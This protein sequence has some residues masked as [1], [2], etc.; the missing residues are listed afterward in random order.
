M[1]VLAVASSK[2]GVG[3]TSVAVNLAAGFAAEGARTLLVDLDPGGHATTWLLGAPAKVGIAD[4]ILA[5]ELAPEHV[6]EVPDRPRLYLAPY[7]PALDGIE[8]ALAG[9]FGRE[10]I[11]AEV[12]KAKRK[13]Q[14]EMVV[15]DCQ[16]TK[17]FLAQSAVFAASEVISP[18]LPGIL[19]VSGV[20][21]I[22][23]LVEQVRK[24]GRG[25][26]AFLGSVI[27]AGD[28]RAMLTQ[29]TRESLRQVHADLFRSEVRVSTA[30]ARLP[31]RRATAWDPGADPRGAEDYSELLKETKQR[32]RKGAN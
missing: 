29:Q 9:E 28:D 3:K 18:C 8:A 32:L 26:A 30:G 16:P 10:A 11:L 2:G 7:S 19:G 1:N 27:F 23:R 20:V 25:R 6:V 21:D 31:E 14:F 24:R 22:L 17:G 13:P 5:G 12:I 15:L 4:A